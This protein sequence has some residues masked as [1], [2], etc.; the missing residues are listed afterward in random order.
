MINIS[1]CGKRPIFCGKKR[2]NYNNCV[3]EIYN[4][5]NEAIV[6]SQGK[7]QRFLCENK[8]GLIYTGIG[9]SILMFLILKQKR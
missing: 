4:N 6:F 3:K 8:T 5:N 2:T 9:L 1:P 7:L